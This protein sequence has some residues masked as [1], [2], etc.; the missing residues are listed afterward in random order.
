MLLKIP[1]A[2]AVIPSAMAPAKVMLLGA[3]SRRRRRRFAAASGP[4]RRLL[5]AGGRGKKR[6]GA[7]ANVRVLS[8]SGKIA[9]GHEGEGQVRVSDENLT[10][11]QR[12]GTLR[13]GRRVLLLRCCALLSWFDVLRGAGMLAL[14]VRV[15]VRVY[16]L[17]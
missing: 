9:A 14:P 15:R 3:G 7:R 5:S 4:Q 1:A 17:I 11:G 16:Q 2:S 12:R 13:R 6:H 10:V 8:S